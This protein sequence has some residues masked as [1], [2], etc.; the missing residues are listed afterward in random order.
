MIDEI[1]DKEMTGKSKFLEM[2][3][4]DF[5]AMADSTEAAIGSWD[6]RFNFGVIEE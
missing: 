3:G 1:S 5:P 4:M 6:Q 2:P